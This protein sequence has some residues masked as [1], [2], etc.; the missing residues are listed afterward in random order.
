M[1]CCSILWRISYWLA[2]VLSLS[3]WSIL[4]FVHLLS[5]DINPFI[6]LRILPLTVWVLS[7]SILFLVLHR[8][9]KTEN[10]NVFSFSAFLIPAAILAIITLLIVF[11]KSGFYTK[12]VTVNDLGVPLL[13]WQIIYV[14]GII[15]LLTLICSGL[16]EKYLEIRLSNLQLRRHLSIFLFFTIW[17]SACLIWVQQPLPKNNYFLPERLP[18]N[19]NPYPFSDAERYSLE[20]LRFLNGSIQDFIIEKPMHT[21]FLA[22]V[23]KIA[24]LDYYRVILVQTIILSIFP[25]VLFLIGKEIHGFR[26]GIGMSMFAIFREVNKIL[27][28]DIANVSNTKLVM[29]DFPAMLILAVLVLVSIKWLKK[30]HRNI[31]PVLLGGIIGTLSLYRAQYLIFFPLLFL[32]SSF[33]S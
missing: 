22:F 33:P 25:A 12:D 2:A 31:Y 10:R 7:L 5:R 24:G 30:P 29:S 18:P 9:P 3:S 26:L 6:N 4:F 27:A 1:V 23:Y 16:N 14:F 17:F 32:L 8:N 21:L 15:L 19:F 28:A 13:E 20:G 11:T